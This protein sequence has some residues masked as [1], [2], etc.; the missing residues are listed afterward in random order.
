LEVRT[1]LQIFL[2]MRS[3]AVRLLLLFRGFTTR[4]L[5]SLRR[6][7]GFEVVGTPWSLMRQAHEGHG[8]AAQDAQRAL[9]E[10]YRRAVYRYMLGA[11]RDAEQAEELFQEF[12]FRFVRGDFR[13][14]NPNAGRFRDYLRSSMSHLINDWRRS[15]RRSP[16]PLHESAPAP[17]SSGE[18]DVFLNSWRTELI[19]QTWSALAADNTNQHAV[20]LYYVQH[21]GCSAADAA[22]A[23]ARQLGRPMTTANVRVQLYR[24]RERFAE[25]LAKEVARTLDSPTRLDLAEEL[26]VLN[27]LNVCKRSLRLWPGG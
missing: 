11:V 26:R 17:D 24:A 20:L 13:N 16:G 7:T 19:N 15:R 10:H 18:D 8:H 6:T 22:E 14:A 25:L 3:A 23:L 2:L 1:P 9:I 27:L 4:L 5:M 21:S 12:A